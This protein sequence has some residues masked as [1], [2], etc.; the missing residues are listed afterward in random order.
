MTATGSINPVLS[1]YYAQIYPLSEYLDALIPSKPRSWTTE[2]DT[3]TFRDLLQTTLVALR[4]STEQ[5]PTYA[6]Y[7]PQCSQSEVKPLSRLNTVLN[8]LRSWTERMESSFNGVMHD[9]TTFLRSDIDWFVPFS[10]YEHFAKPFYQCETK[11]ELGKP[12]PGRVNISN[13]AVNSM[14]VSLT[15]PDWS[16][17]LQRIGEGPMYHLLVS[18]SLFLHVGNDCFCQATGSPIHELGPL[19]LGSR[20]RA[21][22]ADMVELSCAF[23]KQK[24]GEE[25]SLKKPRV[26]S[27]NNIRIMRARMFYASAKHLSHIKLRTGLPA[28][29]L[30]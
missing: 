21:R 14:V 29:R 28:K 6:Y 5:I 2:A 22:P 24:L 20:K 30:F 27:P 18:T 8:I 10:L 19:Q 7:H 26:N 4:S 9:H 23:K 13:Y 16:L 17:L 11:D 12:Q 3:A 1:Q 15:S 25:V